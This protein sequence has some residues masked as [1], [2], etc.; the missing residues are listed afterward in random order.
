[1]SAG[2]E[3]GAIA[4]PYKLQYPNDNF[5]MLDD[6]FVIRQVLIY[7]PMIFNTP[8]NKRKGEFARIE[9]N[10]LDGLKVNP[11]EW[12]CYPARVGPLLIAIYFP[13]SLFELGF[14][15]S[16]LFELAD[17]EDLKRKPDAV[18]IYGAPLENA[19]SVNGN[20]TVFFDDEKG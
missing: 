12:L 2:A 4:L 10:P 6:I 19:L 15:L 16:N 9:K 7:P 11:K 17:E 1:V 18:Y 14:S 13:L 5:K 20:E 8:M 3:V